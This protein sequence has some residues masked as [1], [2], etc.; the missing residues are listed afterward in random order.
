[1]LKTLLPW[2][3]G[4]GQ[5]GREKEVNECEYSSSFLVG[6]RVEGQEGGGR[7][8]KGDKATSARL[9]SLGLRMEREERDTQGQRVEGREG[10]QARGEDSRFPA[11]PL[12][13]RESERMWHGLR[14]FHGRDK[15]NPFPTTLKSVG[16]EGWRSTLVSQWT[17]ASNPPKGVWFPL[18][19]LLAIHHALLPG[20]EHKQQP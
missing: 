9:N 13:G 17:S 16:A 8:R 3:A 4:G 19:H 15:Y 11:M 1:M 18:T 2:I 12:A 14:G 7:G 20:V 6:L 5:E 10:G